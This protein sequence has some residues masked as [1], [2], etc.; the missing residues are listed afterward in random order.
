MINMTWNIA[1]RVAEN[2]EKVLHLIETFVTTANEGHAEA[3][4]RTFNFPHVLINNGAVSVW[5]TLEELRS[6][7]LP[8]L[9]MLRERGWARSVFDSKQIVQSDGNTFHVAVRFTRYDLAQVAVGTYD[10]LYVVTCVDGHWGI[11]ARSNF[12]PPHAS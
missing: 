8:Q 3:H 1:H 6:V 7:Y 2:T 11:Q 4:A 12:V 9:V 10:A 5:Y